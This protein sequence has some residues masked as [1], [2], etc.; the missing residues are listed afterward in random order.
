MIKAALFDLD[1]VV[2]DTESQ[3]SVFWG[4][5]GREYHPEMPDFALRIKGQTL[6][7]IYD[8]YFSDDATFAHIDGYTDCKSEQAKI[9]DRLDEFELNMSFPYIPGFETL[10]RKSV[11]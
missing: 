11:V 10:D 5:I 1:G 9:T 4:M 8:K 3:Y 7:Q 2:F 6:V